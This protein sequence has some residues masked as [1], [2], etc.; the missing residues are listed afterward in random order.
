MQETQVQSLSWEDPLEEEMATHSSILVQRILWA[1]RPWFCKESNATERAGELFTEMFAY[2]WIRWSG[3]FLKI[4]NS[5][6][7]QENQLWKADDRTVWFCHCFAISEWNRV[8]WSQSIAPFPCNNCASLPIAF[9]SM[10]RDLY[11]WFIDS[12]TLPRLEKQPCLGHIFNLSASAFPSVLWGICYCSQ[13]P[14]RWLEIA[15]FSKNLKAETLSPTAI[16]Y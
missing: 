9:K 11:A 14:Q 4:V 10:R 2:S 1:G 3:N 15:Q 5:N 12:T 8:G 7:Y 16:H 13:L 6:M